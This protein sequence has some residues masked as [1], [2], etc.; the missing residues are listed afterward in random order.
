M[1]ILINI[2]DL[3]LT[4]FPDR[5]TPNGKIGLTAVPVSIE[6]DLPTV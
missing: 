5:A 4:D 1:M 3:T 6:E 2:N